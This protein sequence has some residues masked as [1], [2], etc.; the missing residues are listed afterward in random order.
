MELV[1][2]RLYSRLCLGGPRP[3]LSVR[4]GLQLLSTSQLRDWHA[5]AGAPDPQGSWETGQPQ[6]GDWE[7]S[8]GINTLPEFPNRYV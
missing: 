2:L 1:S 6:S 4:H 8:L 7:R 5:A 3:H